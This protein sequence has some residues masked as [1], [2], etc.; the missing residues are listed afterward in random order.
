MT[1]FDSR[2]VY[3]QG[4]DYT[5]PNMETGYGDVFRDLPL[6]LDVQELLARWPFPVPARALAL[7]FAVA[8]LYTRECILRF[9]QTNSGFANRSTSVINRRCQVDFP[10]QWAPHPP[11]SCRVLYAYVRVCLLDVL[12]LFPLQAGESSLRLSLTFVGCKLRVVLLLSLVW[13]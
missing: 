5:R 13:P 1:V 9:A 12:S 6:S 8:S 11:P 7:V 2:R 3:F 10:D 4:Q